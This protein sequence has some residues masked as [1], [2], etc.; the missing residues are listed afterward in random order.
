MNKQTEKTID[1]LFTHYAQS[2]SKEGKDAFLAGYAT[3]ALI[4]PLRVLNEL[5]IITKD[6]F[7]ILLKRKKAVDKERSEFTSGTS[8]YPTS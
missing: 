1:K 2:T 6:E 8:K 7:S 4:E 3:A 5:E